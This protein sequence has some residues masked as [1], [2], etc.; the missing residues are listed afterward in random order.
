MPACVELCGLCVCV[1]SLGIHSEP[2]C[3]FVLDIWNYGSI[4]TVLQDLVPLKRKCC[5]SSRNLRYV[6]HIQPGLQ[7]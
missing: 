5:S 2:S 6:G 1:C 3:W 4:S 7:A